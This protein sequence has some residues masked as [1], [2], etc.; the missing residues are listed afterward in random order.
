MVLIWAFTGSYFVMTIC[1]WCVI[2]LVNWVTTITNCVI[3]LLYLVI[4]VSYCLIIL[5]YFGT[6]VSYYVLLKHQPSNISHDKARLYNQCCL[7]AIKM[8]YFAITLSII[9]NY[10]FYH[11][12]ALFWSSQRYSMS[13]KCCMCHQCVLLCHCAI[14]ISNVITSNNCALILSILL[15]KS[16][17]VLYQWPIIA[18]QCPMCIHCD[19]VVYHVYIVR[20]VLYYTITVSSC[21]ITLS[22]YTTLELFSHL[23][24]FLSLYCDI[25][26]PRTPC[27]L[28]NYNT[29][30]SVLCSFPNFTVAVSN[31][32][33][34]LL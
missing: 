27:A 22:F 28:L 21:D 18:S 6:V 19:I 8:N 20:S 24:D 30:Y 34:F 23:N 4:R 3:T 10:L 16:H 5:E 29:Y 17:I 31:V 33:F 11:K 7:V 26:C 1:W 32:F 25:L 9:M 13:W 14:T 2:T 12:T 15:W